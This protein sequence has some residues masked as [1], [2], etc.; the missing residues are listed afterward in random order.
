MVSKF[1]KRGQKL[2]KK[3]SRF[4]RKA[5]EESREHIEKNLVSRVSHIRTVRLNM[6]EWFLLILAVTLLAITQASWYSASYSVT[7]F[8]DGGT[9]TE[10]TLGKVSSLNPLFASSSSEKSLASLLFANLSENDYSGHTGLGLAKSITTPD[11]GKTWRVLLRDNLKWSDGE[12]ITNDDVIFTVNLIKNPAVITSY[13][14]NLSGVS[15]EESE[16]GELFFHLSSAY[17]DFATALNFPILPEHILSNISPSSLI[18]S[19]FSKN[20]V[21]SGAFK[22]TASQSIGSSGEVVV[23]LSRNENYYRGAPLLD[24]FAIHAYLDESSIVSALNSGAVTATAE[25]DAYDDALLNSSKIY[26]KEAP[27]NSGVFAFFNTTSG[28][29][30][31]KNLRSAVRS[32]VN[33]KEIR[34]AAGSVIALDYPILSSQISLATWPAVPDYD[35]EKSLEIIQNKNLSEDTVVRLVAIK[36]DSQKSVIESFA[37]NLRALGLNVSVETYD[38]TQEFIT[39][40]IQPRSYDILLYEIELG[41]DP[42]LFAYYHSSQAISSGLNL[43]RYNN[44]LADDAILA[45]R[46]TVDGSL[47]SAKYEA[48]LRYWVNDVPA[49]ALYQ[50][51]MVYYYNKN[52]KTFSESSKALFKA[53]S[54]SSS[55]LAIVTPILEP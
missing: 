4:S 41:S 10:A 31:D 30:S 3:F 29:F 9:F 21:S 54:T 55:D 37:E 18:D 11:D 40:I 23:Y 12:P 1:K 53:G 47:R 35:F 15:L 19:D 45:A 16:S 14:S 32:G 27:I 42:D 43:S 28:I 8:T 51:N 26:K 20:P 24:S 22:F 2:S 7:A 46:S 13:S 36:S 49:I 50:S 39:N 38:P 6:L 33:V 17:A 5:G 52:S 25:L 48:F 34:E 44:A